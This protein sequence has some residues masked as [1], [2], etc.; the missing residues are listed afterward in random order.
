MLDF[1]NILFWMTPIKDGKLRHPI[2]MNNAF[3]TFPYFRAKI[4]ILL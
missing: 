2:I 3:L 4:N 1:F